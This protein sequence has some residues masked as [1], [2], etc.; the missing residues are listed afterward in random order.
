MSKSDRQREL[1]RNTK[2]S[3]AAG[4]NARSAIVDLARAA[5]CEELLDDGSHSECQLYFLVRAL[6]NEHGHNYQTIVNGAKRYAHT[7]YRGD[8][9]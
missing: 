5:A 4:W 3:Q 7:I 6:C 1:D 9:R 8:G 2:L